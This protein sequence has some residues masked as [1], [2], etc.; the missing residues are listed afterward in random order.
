M[1]AVI[2]DHDSVAASLFF[3]LETKSTRVGMVNGDLEGDFV[4]TGRS[5]F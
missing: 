1:G 2:C 3:V 4:A 5:Y